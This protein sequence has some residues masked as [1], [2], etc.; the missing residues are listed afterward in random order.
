MNK[1]KPEEKRIIRTLYSANKPLTT[2]RISEKT[3][4]AWQTAKK[5]LTILYKKDVVDKK[6]ME[7]LYFGG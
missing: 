1:F 3:D 2:K 6:N 4:M 5:Y 7:N